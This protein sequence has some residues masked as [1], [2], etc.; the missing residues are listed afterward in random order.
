MGSERY[1]I[2]KI[3]PGA[4]GKVREFRVSKTALKLGGL[5]LILAVFLG[6]YL[7]VALY[8]AGSERIKFAELQ[9]E[10]H[11]LKN[12]L[13]LIKAELAALK[14]TLKNLGQLSAA[15]NTMVGLEAPPPEFKTMGVGG[16][17]EKRD[18]GLEAELD[19]V[20][21]EIDRLL[22]L[23]RFE[24]ENFDQLQKKL[25]SS[26]RRLQHTPSIMPTTGY[27]TSGFGYRR[28]PFTGRIKFHRGIDL[29]APVGTPVIAPADGIVRK[30]GRDRALHGDR[31][32]IWNSDLLRSPSQG[33]GSPRKEGQ[34]GPDNCLCGQ[35]GAIHGTPP[36][37]RGEGKR[38]GS[39]SL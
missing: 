10:N 20:H 6:T 22:G 2:F 4:G 18:G 21:L 30:V 27:F 39:E 1:I 14:D 29:S 25:L 7:G 34:K 33:R 15:L 3:F 37:L 17:I 23:S 38:K 24:R 12:E 31:S 32:R 11:R 13:E 26:R 16:Y 28:D 35:Y 9:K 36:P 19:Y 5:F 8:R